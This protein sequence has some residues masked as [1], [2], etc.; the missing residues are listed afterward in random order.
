M[1]I[2]DRDYMKRPSDDDGEN[3]SS[4]DSKAEEF[5]SRFLQKHPRFLLYVGIAIGA[6]LIIAFFVAKFSN[7]K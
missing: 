7:T 4:S 1:G 6:L 2:R 3:G 5:A